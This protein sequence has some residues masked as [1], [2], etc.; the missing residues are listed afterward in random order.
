MV[1]IAESRD[2][3]VEILTGLFSGDL[4]DLGIAFDEL[5][6]LCFSHRQVD[7]NVP[8]ERSRSARRKFPDPDPATQSLSFHSKRCWS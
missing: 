4:H 8:V 5:E 1:E 6:N 3:P 2:V 7:P